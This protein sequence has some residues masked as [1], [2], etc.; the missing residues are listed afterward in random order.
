MREPEADLPA[1]WRQ[2]VTL[3]NA[4]QYWE[5]HEALVAVWR[6]A[7]ETERGHWQGLIQAAAALLHQSRG[8][9]HGVE[10]LGAA[11]I[12]KLRRES[13]PGFPIETR[14]FA[15][16]LARRLTGAG[17]VPVMREIV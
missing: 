4:G 9:T 1:F 5:A 15:E 3:F 12:G 17:P 11:A 6:G 16:E 10:A 2:G 8:N 14:D 7:P 13:P